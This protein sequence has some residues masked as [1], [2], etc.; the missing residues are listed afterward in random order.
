MF[1]SWNLGSF[2]TLYTPWNAPL[3]LVVPKW[4]SVSFE[5]PL[6]LRR[7]DSKNPIWNT[8]LNINIILSNV[9]SCSTKFIAEI[10]PDSV[11]NIFIFIFK[12]SH[13]QCIQFG[14]YNTN[15]TSPHV[16]VCAIRPLL[17]VICGVSKVFCN[18]R[19]HLNNRARRSHILCLL[20]FKYLQAVCC[21][22]AN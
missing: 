12:S 6:N 4:S 20:L 3:G 22:D 2:K 16:P 8:A 13:V 10:Q 15:P 21:W 19:V 5:S 11:L 18:Q 1:S 9:V 17:A 7:F 14:R